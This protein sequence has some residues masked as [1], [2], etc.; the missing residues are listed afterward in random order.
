MDYVFCSWDVWAAGLWRLFACTRHILASWFKNAGF[1]SSSHT[2]F[3]LFPSP[4][5]SFSS[6]LFLPLYSFLCLALLVGAFISERPSAGTK[7]GS[8]LKKKLFANTVN[9]TSRVLAFL[10]QPELH[11]SNRPIK[12]QLC[13]P[14]P[15][16][17]PHSSVTLHPTAVTSPLED[18][19]RAP[20]SRIL[21]HLPR[22]DYNLL[23][24]QVLLRS[25][26][27]NSSFQ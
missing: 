23:P 4:H 22:R 5:D 20:Q 13:L 9:Y 14:L 2:L 11:S 18:P 19:P 27:M 25:R 12:P 6:L 17:L 1:P 16:P 8:R 21:P 24:F 3:F 7:G 15:S 10:L 26:K